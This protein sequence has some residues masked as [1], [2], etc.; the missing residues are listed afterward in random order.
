MDFDYIDLIGVGGI[1]TALAEPLARLLMYILDKPKLL[2]LWD[3]D[4]VEDKN[5]QRQ[6]FTL[7]EVGKSKV[8]PTQERLER[9]LDNSEV[10]LGTCKFYVNESI[11]TKALS[12]REGSTLVITSVDNVKT[13]SDI[14]KAIRS[15]G[16][17]VVMV[18]PGNG[19]DDGQVITWAGIQGI[20]YGICRL[21]FDED[22]IN[23]PDLI[24]NSCTKAYASTPQLITANVMAASVTIQLL[25]RLFT[26]GEFF[27]EVQFK[28]NPFPLVLPTSKQPI[29]LP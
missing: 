22:Y 25:H 2:T 28:S 9:I 15:S 6:N 12:K 19:L 17:D 7:D 8:F 26:E 14:M 5:L 11:Y 18:S 27:E 3:G 21:D 4:T 24:P 10:T 23:P 29:K 16:K 13:R 20:E 1:G